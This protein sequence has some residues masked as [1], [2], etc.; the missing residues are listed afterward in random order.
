MKKHDARKDT[1]DVKH[2]R[3]K[4]VARSHLMGKGPMEIAELTCLTWPTVPVAIDL[5]EQGGWKALKYR[6]V[7]R[8][9]ARAA[10]WMNSYGTHQVVLPR[11]GSPLRRM[12]TKWGRLNNI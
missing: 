2:E 1:L 4:Q 5:C 8:R 9:K 11:P 6:Q 12:K 10:S 3:R 7:G